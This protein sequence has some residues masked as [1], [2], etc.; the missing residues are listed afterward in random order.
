MGC[1]THQVRGDQVTAFGG[2]LILVAIV[3]AAWA[4]TDV[5]RGIDNWIYEKES[6]NV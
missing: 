3:A 6:P 4:F 1:R 5:L 2:P